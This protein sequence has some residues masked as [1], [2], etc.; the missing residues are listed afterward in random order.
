MVIL[1]DKIRFYEGMTD[2]E[3]CLNPVVVVCVSELSFN[4]LYFLAM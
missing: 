1:R 2:R 3:S 4:Q